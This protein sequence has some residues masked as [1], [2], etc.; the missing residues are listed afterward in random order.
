MLATAH[1][2]FQPFFI[3]FRFFILSF[4]VSI[5]FGKDEIF[6]FNALLSCKRYNII[7][8]LSKSMWQTHH[9][10]LYQTDQCNYQ[11]WMKICYLVGQCHKA[12]KRFLFFIDV[13]LTFAF[14]DFIPS[15]IHFLCLVLVFIFV[16]KRT[17]G[18]DVTVFL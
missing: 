2:S 13:F 5:S 15:F 17:I 16:K 11:F 8:T 6:N 7:M 12:T 18:F 3:N 1:F 9:K 10:N 4:N 14:L